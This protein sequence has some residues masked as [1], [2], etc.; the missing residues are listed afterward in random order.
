MTISAIGSSLLGVSQATGSATES[1]SASDDFLKILL[2]QLKNQDPT[3]P[4]DTSELTS[5]L[6]SLSQL[7]QSIT[8]NSYLETLAQYGAAGNNADALSCIGK[9][10]TTEDVTAALVTGVSF[11][12]GSAYLVT[13]SGE[14]DFGDVTGVSST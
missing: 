8:T 5:Q 2:A 4:M 9:T 3:D 11:K 6:A 7:E 10:V 12:D 13:D 14:I 1:S